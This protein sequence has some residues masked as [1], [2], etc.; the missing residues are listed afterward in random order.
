MSAL[1]EQ[2]NFIEMQFAKFEDCLDTIKAEV[3]KNANDI[4]KLKA[5]H[6]GLSTNLT[7]TEETFQ[8]TCSRLEASTAELEDRSHRDNICIVNLPEKKKIEN[9][10][11]SG[12]VASS[13][14]KWF[15]A[16]AGEKLEV[17]RAHC[18]GPERN[19]R[20]SRRL[21]CKML[22]YTDRYRILK[23]EV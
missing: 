5:D 6:K 12:I 7:K 10:N 23:S 13:L 3:T 22:R 19:T 14:F 11:A 15:P 20:G 16:L 9:S 17:M 2:R 8:S 21:I 4:K 1:E 18:I